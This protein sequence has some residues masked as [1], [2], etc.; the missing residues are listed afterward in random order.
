MNVIDKHGYFLIWYFDNS[1]DSKIR[2]IIFAKGS[3]VWKSQDLVD[4]LLILFC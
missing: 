4:N 3:W 1:K 2:T